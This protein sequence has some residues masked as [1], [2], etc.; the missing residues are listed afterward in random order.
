M[1]SSL[2]AV[3]DHCSVDMAI[4]SRGLVNQGRLLATDIFNTPE[5]RGHSD[6]VPLSV[7]IDLSGKHSRKADARSEEEA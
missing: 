2:V 5:E 7:T 6:H 3:A 4:I 1:I